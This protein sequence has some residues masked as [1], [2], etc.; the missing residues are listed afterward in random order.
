ME[1]RKHYDLM[2]KI[3]SNGKI[4][5]RIITLYEAKNSEKIDKHL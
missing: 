1:I 5:S 3:Q 4:N 2:W